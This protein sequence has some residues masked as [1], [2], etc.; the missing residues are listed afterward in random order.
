M[1]TKSPRLIHPVPR[2]PALQQQLRSQSSD[3]DYATSTRAQAGIRRP[4]VPFAQ[5][6]SNEEWRLFVV[7]AGHGQALSDLG[8][9]GSHETSSKRP[10][11]PGVSQIGQSS[12]LSHNGEA[13]ILSKDLEVDE[14]N[15]MDQ[16]SPTRMLANP[17]HSNE[18]DVPSICEDEQD[19]TS[20]SLKPSAS[21]LDPYLLQSDPSLG[22]IEGK[23]LREAEGL[24]ENLYKVGLPAR[25]PSS[26][27]SSEHI[28]R[29]LDTLPIPQDPKI[30]NEQTTPPMQAKQQHPEARAKFVKETPLTSFMLVANNDM[31]RKF[32][33][34]EPDDDPEEAFEEARKETARILRPYDTH[35]STAEGRDNSEE[36]DSHAELTEASGVSENDSDADVRIAALQHDI[37][38][39]DSQPFAFGSVAS[40]SS[41]VDVRDFPHPND[42]FSAETSA[43]SINHRAT[44]GDAL[45]H[46][47]LEANPPFS[48]ATASTGQATAG[49]SSSLGSSTRSLAVPVNEFSRRGDTWSLAT[50]KAD[51]ASLIVQPPSLR[52]RE[53]SVDN[54]KFTR[55]KAFLGK[56]ARRI[57]EQQHIELSA[58][59]IRG[60][61]QVRRRQ[62][63]TVDG[64][65]IVRKLPNFSSDP[66]ED[67]DD[68]PARRLQKPFMFGPLDTQED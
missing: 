42:Q 52:E 51:D 21:S 36:Q 61:A 41:E 46:P 49:S 2:R 48:D 34:G 4:D 37:A 25:P 64:R 35:I 40:L 6:Q 31:W 8:V 67:P 28:L 17:L 32:I 9:Y 44:A 29:R 23:E 19:N 55:P 16:F 54:L 14:R 22:S 60:R 12:R 62:R 43:A 26:S 11:S 53:F 3:S 7:E 50:H 10:I 57:D 20:A 1:V 47:N 30:N 5:C 45:P 66:I 68:I 13:S 27:N 38:S 18:S 65:P 63:S 33:L 56:K 15:T 58:P 39:Q 59:Q 24:S